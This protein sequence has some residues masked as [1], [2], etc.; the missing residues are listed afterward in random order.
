MK[1]PLTLLLIISALNVSA[2]N[3]V[4]VSETKYDWS[5][6][7]KT[8]TKDKSSK[9]DKAYAIY[10]WLCDNIAYDTSRSIYDSD[11]AIEQYRGV[12]QAYCELYYRLGEAVGLK[13]D[14]VNGLSKDPDGYISPNGHAWLYVYTDGKQGILVDPTWGAGSVNGN[15]FIHSPGDDSWFHVD[16]NWAIF[17]HFPDDEAYQLLGN[18]VDSVTFSRLPFYK[19]DLSHFRYDGSELLQQAL[20]GESPNIPNCYRNKAIG[21]IDTP[22]A[23]TLRIGEEYNFQV[24]NDGG[25]EFIIINGEDYG[26]EWNIS[27]TQYSCS[28]IPSQSDKLKLSYRPKG[29]HGLW[30]TVMEYDIAN[31]SNDDIAALEATAP[32]KSPILKGLSNYRPDILK[33]KGI[34]FSSLLDEVKR[35]NIR[36]LPIIATNAMF[37]LN[38]VPM[39]GVLRAGGNYTF[40][41]SPHEAGDWYIVN[42]TEWLDSWTQDPLSNVWEISVTAAPQGK[43]LIAHRPE[44]SESNSCDVYLEYDIQ[45]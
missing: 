36:Q 42:D 29:S 2:R 33:S 10:R 7:A 21:I 24:S 27:D 37:T 14:I 3:D 39:N 1:Y 4:V 38:S 6:L 26:M 35:D 32:H 18:P 11:T 23:G 20:S 12:C 22:R 28:F 17:S 5:Q 45:P 25:Y 8:I 19:P 9:Y 16:P 40:K 15:T 43:L 30:T 34:D 41:I 31:P 44:G 13:V